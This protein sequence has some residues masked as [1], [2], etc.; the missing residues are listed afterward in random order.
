MLIRTAS[1]GISF[2]QELE[3]TAAQFYADVV[4]S[5]PRLQELASKNA[6]ENRRF[7]KQIQRVYQEVITDAL[8]GGYCFKI[9]ITHYKMPAGASATS[10]VRAAIHLA[11]EL[12]RVMIDFYSEAHEQAEGLLADIPRAFAMIIGKRKKRLEEL[13]I[14]EADFKAKE[15]TD[16]GAG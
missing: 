4:V 3:L 12:E 1:E 15:G 16:H 7:A 11:L 14:L 6:R 9:E 8:E 10:S 5:Q 13:L 2:A